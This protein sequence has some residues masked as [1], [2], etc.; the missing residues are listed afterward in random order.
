MKTIEANGYRTAQE[1]RRQEKGFSLIEVIIVLVVLSIAALGV[2][3][4]FTGGIR[5]S[6]NPLLINQAVSL[7]Q[8]K[9]D[10]AAALKKSGG[11]NAVVPDPGGAFPAPFAD[12]AWN[13]TVDCVAAADLNTS[14]G[15]PPCASEYAHVVVTVTNPIVGSISLDTVVTNH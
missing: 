9:M 6:S 13:R 7:A 11:F 4:A 5:W 1:A 10:E 3:S 8:Q 2:L 12:F 15:A 14:L